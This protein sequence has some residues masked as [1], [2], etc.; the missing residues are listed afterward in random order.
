M[1]AALEAIAKQ[2]MRSLNGEII[3]RLR[4][5]TEAESDVR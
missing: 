5:S 1:K 2:N 3:F 4:Q